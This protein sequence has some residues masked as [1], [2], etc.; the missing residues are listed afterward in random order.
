MSSDHPRLGREPLPLPAILARHAEQTPDAVAYVHLRD[1]EEIGE[2]ATYAELSADVRTRAAALAGLAAGRRSAVL[3]YPNGLEFIRAWL[4]CTATGIKGAPLQVPSRRQ[5]VRRLRTVADD[6]RTTLVL[7]TCEVRDRVLDDFAGLPELDGLEF[8]ATDGL[9]PPAA[10]TASP[11]PALSDVALL[12]Y[13][14]GSTG[15]PKGVMVTHANFWANASEMD[16]LWPFAED[17]S[18]VSWLPFFHD[19][20]LL[21]G[22]V[23]PLWAGRPAYLM[24]PEAFV[25]RP[26]RWLEALSRFG[27]THAAAPNFAYDLCVRAD[28]PRGPLDLSRWRVAINGAEP[29]RAHTVAEFTGKFAPHGFDPKAM[30]PGYGLAEYTLKISGSPSDVEP[31]PLVVDAHALGSGRVVRVTDDADGAPGTATVMSCGHTV[32]DARVRVVDPRTLRA[33]G[34]DEVGEIWASGPCVAAGYLGREEESERTFRARIVDEEDEGPF[35][36]TGDMGFVR[37]GEVFVTGRLKDLIIVKGRNHYPQDLEHTV[38]NSHPLLR[39]ASSAAFAVDDGEREAVVVVVEGDRRILTYASADEV[40]AAV[41]GALLEHHRIEVADVVLIRRGTLP[42]TTSGKVRRRSCAQR[43]ASGDLARLG[44]PR[45][46]AGS[47]AA[48]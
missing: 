42:K 18:V 23:L 6:A 9:R 17:G 4:A 2:Q 25:R 24:G 45:P 41:R 27:G 30:C 29:V 28:G 47:F 19:M 3:M 15:D 20:G 38:E 36:R 10:G 5:A 14:S 16:E 46:A 43:Y 12:Q 32:A 31:G 44:E 7:T 26:A 11:E 33:V 35:L 1:G 37:G 22:V 39:P 40:T 34:D 21:L 13:T 48:T 8:V